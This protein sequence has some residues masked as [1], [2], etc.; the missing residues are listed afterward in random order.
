[1]ERGRWIHSL[2]L[3]TCL[4]CA[5]CG[6]SYCSILCWRMLAYPLLTPFVEAGASD[7]WKASSVN[8]EYAGNVGSASGPSRMYLYLALNG[9]FFDV[10]IFLFFCIYGCYVNHSA[11]SMKCDR[12]LVRVWFL[13]ILSSSFSCS[14]LQGFLLLLSIYRS[15][16]SVPLVLT[17]V[18]LKLLVICTHF[19][20]QKLLQVQF[21]VFLSL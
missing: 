15:Q 6:V 4:P 2:T 12:R 8:S 3:F 13:D 16:R 20:L 18:L 7:I 11:R 14:S 21:P 17:I 9:G 5:Q 10:Y 1:M 19:L